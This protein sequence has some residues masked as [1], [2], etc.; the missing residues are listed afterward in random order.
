MKKHY[1]D[2]EKKIGEV[3][4]GA[5]RLL[6]WLVL[7]VDL[8]P[9]LAQSI[10]RAI[11]AKI[12]AKIA[13]KKASAV[14]SEDA[15]EEKMTSADATETSVP[16]FAALEAEATDA[17]GVCRE[18]AE[19]VEDAEDTEEEKDAEELARTEEEADVEDGEKASDSFF[20]G[21]STKGLEFVDVMEEPKKY[22]ALLGR[23]K[24]GEVRLVT[25]Y[26]RT[27]ASK[28]ALSD[29]D[30][31]EYYSA[32]KNKLLSYRGVKSRS[33]R[34]LETFSKGRTYIAKLDVKSK[35]LYLYLG[36][37]PS[38][39]ATLEGGKYKVKD[40]SEKKKYAS[41]PT[42]F[43]IKGPRKMKYALELVDRL[44]REELSLENNKKFKE[45]DY[46]KGAHTVMDLVKQGEMRML[47]AAVPLE[48]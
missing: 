43:K 48:K 33:S 3:S 20:K 5:K 32:L 8:I 45:Q 24:R 39:V 22:K 15:E 41:V 21:F 27:F 14:V 18:D 4:G 46:T 29:K 26:R 13:A 42:L 17:D 6:S 31:Q 28:V 11:E 40:L 16:A 12:A 35:S 1:M 37:D 10:D 25:R 36:M 38:K 44:C 2:E 30:V 23:E 34:T 7:G 47:V 9:T 19:D